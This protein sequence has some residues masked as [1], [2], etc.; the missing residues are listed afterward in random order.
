MAWLSSPSATNSRIPNS[1]WCELRERSAGWSIADPGELTDGLRQIVVEHDVAGGRDAQRV[2]DT[3]GA[4]PFHE[5]AAGTV[6]QRRECGVVILRHRQ[7]DHL[8]RRMVLGEPTVDLQ[9]GVL[10]EPDV[11]Q[12]QVGGGRGDE[13]LDLVGAF[14]LADEFDAVHLADRD[15]QTHPE[16]RMIV[17]DRNTER[18]HGSAAGSWTWT[19][20]P[21]GELGRNRTAP[22]SSAA[23][24]RIAVSPTPSDT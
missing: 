1:R 16:H 14:G 8:H 5:V 12:H 19:R 21:R 11:E 6:A 3:F 13:R 10:T 9:A 23:R 4:G 22:P 17:D 7:H 18:L 24:S 20:V 15:R 2:L